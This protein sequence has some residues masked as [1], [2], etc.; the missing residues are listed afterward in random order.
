MKTKNSLFYSLLI[1]VASISLALILFST[2]RKDGGSSPPNR[3][4][5]DATGMSGKW[6]SG[7]LPDFGKKSYYFLDD[8]NFDGSE[9]DTAFS[10]Y[11]DKDCKT[12]IMTQIQIGTFFL[13]SPIEG[14]NAFTVDLTITAVKIQ[15]HTDSLVKA[16][17]DR[18][19]CGGGWE[20]NVERLITKELCVQGASA[21]DQPDMIYE[22]FEVRENSLYFGTKDAE[23]GGKTPET[24]PVVIDGSRGYAKI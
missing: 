21:G 10:S 24:R 17:N 6:S 4:S 7:C 12:K 2:C 8:R 9:F 23:H 5:S 1:P 18:K 15:L 16:Y 14:Q 3:G 13:G 22:L 11:S 20:I 19:F